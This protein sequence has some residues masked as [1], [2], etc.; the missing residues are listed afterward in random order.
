MLV[1][2]LWHLPN[3][4]AYRF[5]GIHSILP[6]SQ[7]FKSKCF[8]YCHKFRVEKNCSTMERVGTCCVKLALVQARRLH[9]WSLLFR[10]AYMR[11]IS[12]PM[13]RLRSLFEGILR[14]MIYCIYSS[15]A[16]KRLSRSFKDSLVDTVQVF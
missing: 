13:D 11:S 16:T 5:L 2:R 7:T 10:P 12:L 3:L 15:V 6:R 1:S 8:L 4:C 9:S 14:K